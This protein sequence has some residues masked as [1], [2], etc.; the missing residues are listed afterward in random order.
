MKPLQPHEVVIRVEV[1]DLNSGHSAVRL[2]VP[3]AVLRA[4]VENGIG[5][6]CVQSE[7][8]NDKCGVRDVFLSVDRLED[9]KQEREKYELT[10][11]PSAHGEPKLEG[12]V[13][14]SADSAWWHASDGRHAERRG[15]A[16][17]KLMAY[18]EQRFKDAIPPRKILMDNIR[19]I[20]GKAFDAGAGR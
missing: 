16:V 7:D 3:A 6:L 1:F 20:V 10:E 19:E 18:V 14:A 5:Q 13:L 4:L 12:Y 9:P 2:N 11:R 15:E 17:G 8:M